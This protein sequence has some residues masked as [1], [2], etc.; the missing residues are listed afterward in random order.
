[1]IIVT[2]KS[3]VSNFNIIKYYIINYNQLTSAGV[4][5]AKCLYFN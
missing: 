3:N 4:S 5:K 1:M 2:S